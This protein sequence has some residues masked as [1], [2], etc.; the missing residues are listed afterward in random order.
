[1]FAALVRAGLA[2]SPVSAGGARAAGGAPGL[3]ARVAA[4]LRVVGK[5]LGVAAAGLFLKYLAFLASYKL[6]QA[7]RHLP[8]PPGPTPKPVIGNLDVVISEPADDNGNPR[9]HLALMREAPKHKGLYGLWMGD[10]YTVVITKPEVAEEAFCTHML[11]AGYPAKGD[12]TT[13][14]APLQSHG[15]HHV[16]SMY[17]MTRD[18]KGIAMS[19]GAYW[20]KVRGRLVSH[21]T[22]TKAAE[23]NAFLIF[24]EVQSVV[25]EWRRKVARGEKVDNLTSQ[26]KRES[27]NMAM[28]VLFGKR[29]GASEPQ[30][31]K[32]LKHCV[33]WFFCNLSSGNPSD[34]LH[35][36][37]VLPNKFL[38]K[39]QET[40][41][42]RD[43]VLGNLIKEARDQ[44]DA[45]RAEGRMKTRA[46]AR[47]MLD[48]F[49]FDQVEGFEEKDPATGKTQLTFLTEEETH[50]CVWDILFAMTDTTATTNE[51]MVYHMINNPEVQAKVHAELDRVVGPD[52]LPT[53]E[54]R[55]RLPYLWAVLK[56]VMRV[57]IVSPIMAPHYSTEDMTLHDTEGKEY[58]VP[59]G[60]TLYLH[61]YSMALDPELWEEP[62][63]FNPD[64]WFTKEN[65]G[66]D[67]TGQVKRDRVNHYKFIPFSLGPRMCPGYSFAKVA[68]YLQAASIMH[69]MK[70]GLAPDAQ[71]VAPQFLHQG[72]KLDLSEDWG[73]TIMPRHYG[74][75]GM[76][77]AEARPAAALCRNIEGDVD[78]A[79]AFLKREQRQKLRLLVKEPLSHDTCL[80]RFGLPHKNMVLGLPVGKHFKIYMP[81]LAGVEPG[82]WNGQDDH[83][84][85][86]NE[87]ERAYTPTTGNEELGYVDLVV[88]VY[89]AG[90]VARFP[91][92]GKVSQQLDK[93]FVGDTIDVAGPFGLVEYQGKS[94]FKIG[95]KPALRKTMVGMLAGGSGI[96]PMLQV[97]QAS[98]ADEEDLTLFSLIYAN[99]TEQDIL[100][101]DKLEALAK[102]HPD[103]FK[104]HYTVD[105]PTPG[106]KY[107]AGFITADMLKEHMPP[108]SDET[109]VLMCGPPPMIKF[110]CKANL[111]ALGYAKEAQ[112]AF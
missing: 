3:V 99:Q 18:G 8:W 28:R 22:N 91:D 101:R 70:W 35:F 71:K 64:R 5:V 67:L 62:E 43:R 93:L 24:E 37:R 100:V 56:E 60:T 102:K 90:Q 74:E 42:L 95:S 81:N 31:F 66:L 77:S 80:L 92:G 34:M 103:R 68:Q 49:F 4:A 89:R 79:H 96:T 1:M 17:I 21:I 9:V 23:K 10:M 58:F 7:R 41:D 87:I 107:S 54:H 38:D 106:W 19:Q 82:K 13:D 46:S 45:M 47:G 69:C 15:G 50:V 94:M 112:I 55:D 25:A 52:A 85:D 83:E 76:I 11:E 30:D 84:A 51:W 105:R 16:P 48:Q 97:L 29:F 14:R 36:L 98:L 12:V 59:R 111:D 39:A 33:E 20:R 57:K 88:K 78:Y 108:V 65:E 6:R 27:M 110:A 2:A 26:L 61:G 32:D 75:M 109:L 40:A 73:L 86:K 44:W 104:L 72:G 63:T 53:L